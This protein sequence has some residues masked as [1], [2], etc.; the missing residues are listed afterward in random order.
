MK[1]R[2]LRAQLIYPLN[3]A[4]R[5]G[6]SKHLDR[7]NHVKTMKYIYSHCSYSQLYDFSMHL[8]NYL[9]ENFPDIHWV[10]EITPDILQSFIDSRGRQWSSHTVTEYRYLFRKFQQLINQ[11]YN[12]NLDAT[13]LK[14]PRPDNIS[15]RDV[16]MAS[17]HF[18]QLCSDLL[19]SRTKARF[20]PLLTYI[21][22]TRLEEACSIKPEEIDLKNRLVYLNNCKNGRNRTV[23]FD[24][25]FLP[26]LAEIKTY[27]IQ[28][29]W[30][31][32]CDSIKGTSAARAIRNS[33]KRLGFSDLYKVTSNHAIRKLYA[34]RRLKEELEKEF[35]INRAWSVVQTELGHGLKC[36]NELFKAYIG[37]PL[38][39][40]KSLYKRNTLEK[41]TF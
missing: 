38:S 17:N 22:G 13:S 4:I 32:V 14:F 1:R 20:I 8:H 31:T 2:S 10:R 23:P 34:K 29:N 39:V 21:I 5:Y 6:H 27:C 37:M 24:A 33:M 16:S 18:Y 26:A 7:R 15:V 11:T 28:N 19:N 35:N 40:F 36:R 30:K 41:F 25:D 3:Q 9:R 12:L